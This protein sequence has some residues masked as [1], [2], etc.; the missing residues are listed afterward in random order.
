M[1]SFFMLSVVLNIIMLRVG[2]ADG[3]SGECHYSECAMLS[4]IM[5]SVIILSDLMLSVLMLSLLML[6]VIMFPVFMLSVLTLIVIMLPF[7]MSSVIILI[8]V[9]PRNSFEAPKKFY[10]TGHKVNTNC[11]LNLLPNLKLISTRVE[12]IK[13]FMVVIKTPGTVITALHFFITCRLAK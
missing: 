3:D 4:V 13:L 6:S 11:F 1:L 12:T 7:F 9:A 10:N 8:G 5:L 2:Y